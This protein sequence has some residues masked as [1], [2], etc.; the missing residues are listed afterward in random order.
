MPTNPSYNWSRLQNVYYDIRTCYD[1]LNWSID[2]I[3]SNFKISISTNSTLIALASKNVPYPN[4]IDIYSISGNK[5]WSIVYNSTQSDYILGFYFKNEELVLL[6]NNGKYRHYLDFKGNFNEY[7]IY[8]DIISLDNI[9]VNG[10]SDQDNL[11]GNEINSGR[12][13]TNLENNETEEVTNIL[14]AQVY[15]Q[16]LII[17]LENKLIISDLNTHQNFE[18]KLNQYVPKDIEGFAA[19]IEHKSE[20]LLINLAWKNTVLVIGIDFGLS[21]YEILDQELTDGPFSSISI[22]ES[23]QLISLHNESTRKIFVVSS[24][25]DQV[26]L[27]YDTAN[28]S[29][30]PYQVE[31][32][33]NDAIVLSFKDEVKLIGPGQ[34]SISFFYDIDD[35]DEFDI[36]NLL[37]KNS[38]KDDL[39]YTIPILHHLPD[40][41]RILTSNKCQFLSRVPEKIVS[42]YQIGS[43]SPS[44]L[45]ADCIDKF[46]LNASKAN[47]N[48][49]FL[50]NDNLLPLAMEDCLNVALYEFDPVWQKRAL[51]AA[52][53]G[54]I[55]DTENQFDSNEYLGAL[56]IVKVLNQLRS[57]ELGLFLTYSEIEILGWEEVVKMLLRRDQHYLSLKIID[58]LELKNLLPVVYIHYCCTLIRNDSSSSDSK[59]FKQILKKL[60]SGG[61][62]KTNYITT[63]DI[64]DVADEEG[65]TE[66]RNSLI[67]IDPSITNKIREYISYEESELALIKSFQSGDYDLSV[68]ILIY[69]QETTSLSDFFKILNQNEKRVKEDES[70]INGEIDSRTEN[71]PVE[72][73]VI[74][75]TWLSSIGELEPRIMEKFLSHQDRSDEVDLYKLKQFRKLNSN[76]EGED[77]YNQYKKLLQKLIRKSTHHTSIKTF[78]RELDLL[79]K[80]KKLEEIYSQ[81]FYKYQSISAVI[82]QLISMHQIKP[83]SKLVKEFQIGQEKFWYLVL[84]T[85]SKTKDYD[86]LYEFVFGSLDSTSAKSPIGFEPFIDAGFEFNFPRRHISAYI[87]NSV[88]YKYD[89]KVRLFI[90]ND[91]YESAAQEAFKN[92]DVEIL[93]NLSKNVPQTNS[94]AS[95]IINSYIKKLGY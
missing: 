14:E 77:Y 5:I 78:Q 33:G 53:F 37:L 80:Q 55:Y 22:S 34:Q 20:R 15:R 60:I 27:E 95:N 50:K 40:G 72:G 71:I 69:L 43:N 41:I 38:S 84:S 89:E 3:H 91:D 1:H 86:R 29:S 45:L 87:S 63:S 94:T 64:V 57:F 42:M 12:L 74:G 16:Y 66:L 61:N 73:D 49:N 75:H 68:L 92:K 47:A 81:S 4:L 82:K 23:G 54:K 10:N 6:L 32:C 90:R 24:A 26:L 36:D 17:R 39:S 18:I 79:E 35:D 25:F 93:K 85:Y 59:L 2:N 76:P 21:N 48:I 19:H 11:N 58:K 70:N 8:S 67:N 31:W 9:S 52:S 62:D 56:N 83:A 28:E 51:R 65:R 88:K 30:S 44:G 46:E 7:Q 13:I